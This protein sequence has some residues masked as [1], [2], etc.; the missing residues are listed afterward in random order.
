MRSAGGP[1]SLAGGRGRAAPGPQ[2]LIAVLVAGL[3]AA[4][5]I[6]VRWASRPLDVHGHPYVSLYDPP[7]SRAE[8]MLVKGD[9]QAFAALARDPL[10][11]RPGVFSSVAAHEKPGEEAA[12]RAGRPLFGWLGWAAS[13]GDPRAVP[14]ALLVLTG[15]GAMV[16][17]AG[18]ALVAAHEARRVDLAVLAVGLPG[19]IALFASAGPEA[20]GTG[21]ALVGIVLWCR[22]RRW[23]AVALLTAAA[24]SRETLVLVPLTIA[25][26]ELARRRPRPSLLVPPVVLGGWYVVVRARF[27][28]FPF[29]AGRGRLSAPWTSLGAVAHWGAGDAAFAV[30]GVAL[31]LGGFRRLPGT[32]RAVT[33]G[34]VALALVMGPDVWRDWWAFSR[35][36]LPLYALAL[37]GCLPRQAPARTLSPDDR[38]PLGADGGVVAAGVH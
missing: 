11:S 8:A 31:L 15:L 22:E 21:L 23:P 38:R 30:L 12:Y 14:V 26:V 17:V 28:Y 5:A 20:L 7:R 34:Y 19:S 13:L 35:P 33:A 25:V 36:L 16:L 29:S 9:G 18:V 37:L 2:V 1:P 27:G 24:L 32:Y 4:L 10:L 6:G 3:V